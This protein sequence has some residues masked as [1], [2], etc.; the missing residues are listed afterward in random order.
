MGLKGLAAGDPCAWSLQAFVSW[1]RA[2][3]APGDVRKPP[4]LCE[5]PE[6]SQTL[7]LSLAVV[8]TPQNLG[9]GVGGGDF[10]LQEYFKCQSRN[11]KEAAL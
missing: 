5:P 8:W 9:P 1:D 10:Y 2:V 11:K 7:L 4:R 6:R 3:P